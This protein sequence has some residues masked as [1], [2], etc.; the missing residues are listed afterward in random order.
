[1]CICFKNANF[2][3][4][5]YRSYR[6]VLTL[7]WN[8]MKWNEMLVSVCNAATKSFRVLFAVIN[9]FQNHVVNS[10]VYIIRDSVPPYCLAVT[11]GWD[12]KSGTHPPVTRINIHTLETPSS[13]THEVAVPP[14]CQFTGLTD[15]GREPAKTYPFTLGT[16]VLLNI[17]PMI[18]E[19]G[20]FAGI[21]AVTL[22]RLRLQ[23]FFTYID[24]R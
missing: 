15:P 17:S 22:G 18:S 16:A 6:Y 3:V 23:F 8:E 13:C 14:N 11:I 20:Y 1:M 10:S 21:V 24:Y 5:I 9:I 4:I 12:W 2:F 19:P 7:K